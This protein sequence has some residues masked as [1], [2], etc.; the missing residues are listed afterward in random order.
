MVRDLQ[1]KKNDKHE[2]LEKKKSP[3]SEKEKRGKQYI[4]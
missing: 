3:T 4:I 2:M 1:G